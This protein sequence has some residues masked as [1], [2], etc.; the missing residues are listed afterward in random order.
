MEAT[1]PFKRILPGYHGITDKNGF[2]ENWALSDLPE[3]DTPMCDSFGIPRVEA[4]C[5][6]PKH[7][8]LYN[9]YVYIY[10]HN[11]NSNSNNVV[12]IYDNK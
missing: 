9:M 5:H 7:K 4:H 12:Y 10:I 6:P 11:D 3:T 2:W 1:I 8:H